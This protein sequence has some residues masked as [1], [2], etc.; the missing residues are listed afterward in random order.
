MPASLCTA[1]WFGATP[2]N[3]YAAVV[4]QS[5]AIQ[6]LLLTGH[7]PG[8][9]CC[10]QY[11]GHLNFVPKRGFSLQSF[12][13]QYFRPMTCDISY[14]RSLATLSH[15]GRH[16][17]LA[18]TQ[19]PL[20]HDAVRLVDLTNMKSS[21]CSSSTRVL[22]CFHCAPSQGQ[23]DRK[24]LHLPEAVCYIREREG[25]ANGWAPMV[26]APARRSPAGLALGTGRPLTCS[27]CACSALV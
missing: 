17:I 20:A 23:T 24:E 18:V 9:A 15:Q 2:G 22:C 14:T 21:S 27:R 19:Q 5:S 3:P 10:L 26:A 25:A 1:Q 6:R 7:V 16:G 8:T 12:S 11:R 4:V 13:M